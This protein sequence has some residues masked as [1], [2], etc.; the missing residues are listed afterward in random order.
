MALTL[1]KKSQIILDHAR[2]RTPFQVRVSS[3]CW[4]L[5]GSKLPVPFFWQLCIGFPAM[6]LESQPKYP[7]CHPPFWRQYIKQW[8]DYPRRTFR[9]GPETRRVSNRDEERKHVQHPVKWH[10]HLMNFTSPWGAFPRHGHH[11]VLFWASVCVCVFVKYLSIQHQMRWHFFMVMHHDVMSQPS[12]PWWCWVALRESSHHG[13]FGK[14]ET[15]KARASHFVW[16]MTVYAE[17]TK[18]LK[19]PTSGPNSSHQEDIRVWYSKYYVCVYIYVC[20][21]FS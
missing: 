21:S 14:V 18:F 20:V 1:A 8:P 7:A 2:E 4:Y 6:I 16:Y 13:S 10:A 15:W 12:A 11:Q 3:S 19:H 9:R 17:W 5:Q